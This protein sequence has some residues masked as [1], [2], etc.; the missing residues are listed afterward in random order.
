[1]YSRR[2]IDRI[3]R[4]LDRRRRRERDIENRKY[5][6]PD[7]RG[8]AIMQARPGGVEFPVAAPGQTYKPGSKAPTGSHTGFPGELLLQAAIVGGVANFPPIITHVVIPAA[9]PLTVTDPLSI[10]FTNSTTPLAV[11]LVGTGFKP[12][13]SVQIVNQTPTAFFSVSGFVYHSATSVSFTVTPAAQETAM[14]D[15][16]LVSGSK[17]FTIEEWVASVVV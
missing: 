4:H 3:N 5:V 15:L 10:Q 8:T 9:T 2:D 14:G 7:G 1:M 13:M 17:T 16:Y 11:D 12:G 6:R